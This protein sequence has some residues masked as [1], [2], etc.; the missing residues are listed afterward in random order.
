MGR[1][2]KVYTDQYALKFLLD[3]RLSSIP[4]HQ[5]VSK[6]FGF[7]FA[8]E[9]KPG[10]LNIVADALS[11]KEAKPGTAFTLTAPRFDLTDELPSILNQVVLLYIKDMQSIK[12]QQKDWVVP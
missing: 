12:N 8:V 10:H 7:D 1:P 4:Q 5:W 2:F 3:Q 6:L 9:F 11:R